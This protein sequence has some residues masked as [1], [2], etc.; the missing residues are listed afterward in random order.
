MLT[1]AALFA[2]RRLGLWLGDPV[3]WPLL[4]ASSGLALIL[5]QV[6]SPDWHDAP[7]SPR[8][9]GRGDGDPGALAS[10]ATV[11]RLPWR[12]WP[13][14]VLGSI[15]VVGAALLVLRYQGILP[16]SGRALGEASILLFAL[17]IIVA[18][19]LLGQ[20]RRLSRERMQRIRSEERAEMAA[21]LHDSVLQTLALIQRQADDPVQVVGLAR[22]Q[23]R[24]LRD[25]LLSRDGADPVSLRAGLERPHRRSRRCTPCGWKPSWS[26]TARSTAA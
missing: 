6:M 11:P 14:G 8:A 7:P 4:L 2:L 13:A 25:W 22:A 23:E 1:V 21:H 10:G 15:L 19:F 3:V 9:A 12:R 17:A 26:A 16:L 18:P 24:E 5:R 20:A